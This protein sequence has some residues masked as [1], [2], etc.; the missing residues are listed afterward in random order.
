VM[1]EDWGV[2]EEERLE[3][4]AQYAALGRD[5]E[6][7]ERAKRDLRER[8]PRSAAVKRMQEKDAAAAAKRVEEDNTP[9]LKP[10]KPEN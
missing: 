9:P 3:T 10:I 1:E 4:A 6:R 8:F 7:A 5:N 2:F